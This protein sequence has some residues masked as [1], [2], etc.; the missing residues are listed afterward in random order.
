M[1]SWESKDGTETIAEAF[2][3]LRNGCRV[4]KDAAMLVNRYVE[5][6]KK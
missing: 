3:K 6:W 1:Y 2:V 5:V 4:N